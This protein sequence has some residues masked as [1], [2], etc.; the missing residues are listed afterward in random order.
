MEEPSDVV[1]LSVEATARWVANPSR[2][3]SPT[4]AAEVHSEAPAEPSMPSSV[5][6][7]VVAPSLPRHTSS[8]T[9]PSTS[10]AAMA[11][12]SAGAHLAEALE[13]VRSVVAEVEVPSVAVEA[14]AEVAVSADDDKARMKTSI[15]Q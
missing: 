15:K 14:V 9:I 1:L 2:P 8:V 11:P 7:E 5:L 4:A 3:V 12:A 13:A 10:L 6:E